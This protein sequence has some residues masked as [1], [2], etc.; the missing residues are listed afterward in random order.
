MAASYWDINGYP[1]TLQRPYDM[2][3]SHTTFI[4][5]T[6]YC[7]K[8]VRINVNIIFKQF[9]TSKD[10]GNPQGRKQVPVTDEKI[11]DHL[12]F[13]FNEY[14]HVAWYLPSESDTNN[15]KNEND[16]QG[17]IGVICAHIFFDS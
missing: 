9:Q 13:T 4:T 14:G 1:K 8:N 7:R 2:L 6:S 3:H 5:T 17:Y 10:Q 12:C 15:S 16:Q 11:T